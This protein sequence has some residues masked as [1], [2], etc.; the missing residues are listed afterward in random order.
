MAGW[1]IAAAGG[2]PVGLDIYMPVPEDNPLTPE[3]IAQGRQLF[4]DKRLVTARFPAPRATILP[5]R[6][7]PRSP[8]P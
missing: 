1:T 6:S 8:L 3:K 2:P 7:P 4:F 5:V